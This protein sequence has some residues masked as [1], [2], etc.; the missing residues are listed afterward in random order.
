MCQIHANLRIRFNNNGAS[1]R[2][3][4]NW[5]RTREEAYIFKS[6]FHI[7][8]E[9]CTTISLHPKKFTSNRQS[10]SR[11]H[12]L[13]FQQSN[14]WSRMSLDRQLLYQ[15][16]YLIILI[17]IVKEKFERRYIYIFIREQD[18]NNKFNLL[19]SSSILESTW[20]QLLY[21]AHKLLNIYW[22]IF[23]ICNAI[24]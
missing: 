3:N 5:Y 24:I 7:A 21:Y 22:K 23:S 12:S 17:H 15:Q 20:T 13:Q 8:G 4:N 16:L 19:I 9:N 10:K 18:C 14:N 6:L 11:H 1:V 2:R